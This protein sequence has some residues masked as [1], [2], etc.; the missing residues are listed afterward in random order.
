MESEIHGGSPGRDG[1]EEG[2]RLGDGQ[3]WEWG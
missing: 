2:L 1:V 3:G